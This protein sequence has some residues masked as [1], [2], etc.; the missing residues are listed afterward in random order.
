MLQLIESNLLVSDPSTRSN[1]ADLVEILAQMK[2]WGDIHP[3]YWT[4][5]EDKSKVCKASRRIFSIAP[6][7]HV[8]SASIVLYLSKRQDLLK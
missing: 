7:E 1:A 5:L 4:P 6:A 2:A 8:T 3:E